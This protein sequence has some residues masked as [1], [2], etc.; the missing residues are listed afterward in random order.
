MVFIMRS[1]KGHT[2]RPVVALKDYQHIIDVISMHIPNFIPLWPQNVK[3]WIKGKEGNSN[4]SIGD[5]GKC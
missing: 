2:F 1:D 4:V 3:L 5:D